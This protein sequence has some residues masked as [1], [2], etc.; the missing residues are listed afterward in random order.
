MT[1][2][3][4]VYGT[5]KTGEANHGFMED[6]DGQLVARTW[7]TG[8]QL[9]DM[10]AFPVAMPGSSSQ[11]IFGE[12]Y[13]VSTLAIL[14]MLEGYPYHYQRTVIETPFGLTWIYYQKHVFGARMDTGLWHGDPS[15][16]RLADTA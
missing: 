7:I 13:T 1:E 12:I 10:G 5:L 16:E 15:K 2:R 11:E 4:F 8:W 14:D 6:S 9:V 3:V